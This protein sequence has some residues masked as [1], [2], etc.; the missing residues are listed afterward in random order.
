MEGI[1]HLCAAKT[2][3]ME[4]HVIP[5]F[6]Y[7]WLKDSSGTGFL[8]FGLEP[9]KRVQDGYK[10]YWLCGDCESRLNVWETRFSKSVFHPIVRGTA[11]RIVYG[12][13]LLKFCVSVSWRVLN[14]FINA[15][16]LDHF[17]KALQ[18]KAVLAHDVWKEVLLGKRDHPGMCEQHFLPLD[19][20][21]SFTIDDAPVNINRYILRT[22]DMDAVCGETN[23]FIY[24]K[25]ER[26]V[27][28]GF[29]EMPY[30]RHWQGTKVQL[31]RGVLEPRTYMLPKA[32]GDYFVSKARRYGVVQSSISAN[33]QN[34]IEESYRKN[35]EKAA[36]SETVR[37]M[38]Q[39]VK[40]F[41][42]RAFRKKAK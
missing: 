29:I 36:Q 13:W 16:E 8:R 18:D 37:A 38:T 11:Q 19:A 26:F 30:P 9:N 1:C 6:V 42:R 22:V 15:K 4:S 14:Y 25:L 40:L 31:R 20:I 23:A 33:Q 24:S 28:I 27:I 5:S 41:G 2:E 39:D 3:L 7:K 21:E 10:L 17:P 35:I 32:F 12:D 34:K